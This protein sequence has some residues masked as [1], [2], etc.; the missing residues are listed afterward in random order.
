MMVSMTEMA[1]VITR[2][3]VG[4]TSQ[5]TVIAL[6]VLLQ[7]PSFHDTLVHGCKRM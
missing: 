5:R 1:L 3:N 6:A 2:R 7:V 4:R